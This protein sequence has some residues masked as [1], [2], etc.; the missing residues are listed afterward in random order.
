MTD[1]HSWL[2]ATMLQVAQPRAPRKFKPEIEVVKAE[3]L[4]NYSTV[5][6][7]CGESSRACVVLV[8]ELCI[9][10]VCRISWA[11]KAHSKLL[12][13]LVLETIHNSLLQQK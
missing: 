9:N 2:V 13:A 11:T 12:L 10:I 5:T 6:L 4:K 1:A 8:K 3:S 7:V